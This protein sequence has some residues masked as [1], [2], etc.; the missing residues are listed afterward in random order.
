MNA[1]RFCE[2]VCLL[3]LST[4][5]NT[6]TYEFR[7]GPETAKHIAEVAKCSDLEYVES[8][9]AIAR[10]IEHFAINSAAFYSDL[11]YHH[12]LKHCKNK[13]RSDRPRVRPSI[14]YKAGFYMVEVRTAT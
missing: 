3:Y 8:T 9:M 11:D 6:Q 14:V 7:E 13:R 1:K 4:M 12:K 10:E 2:F 5:T